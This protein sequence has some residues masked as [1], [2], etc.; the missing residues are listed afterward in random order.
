M[1]DSDVAVL[2]IKVAVMGDLHLDESAKTFARFSALV[3][4]VK[5]YNPDLVLLVLLILSVVVL[6]RIYQKQ[7]GGYNLR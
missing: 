5:S 7:R 2:S 6:R 1:N 4:E 3:E